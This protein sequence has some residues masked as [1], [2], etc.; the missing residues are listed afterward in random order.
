MRSC[1]TIGSV[2]SD[3]TPAEGKL[4]AVGFTYSILVPILKDCLIFILYDY[5]GSWQHFA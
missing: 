2:H 4:L 3:V 5:I 1:S